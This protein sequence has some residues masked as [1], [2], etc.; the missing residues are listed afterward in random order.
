MKEK[1]LRNPP[2]DILRPT[3]CKLSLLMYLKLIMMMLRI[4]LLKSGVPEISI[5]SNHQGLIRA[6]LKLCLEL[7]NGRT[8]FYA[9]DKYSK[10]KTEALELRGDQYT[11]KY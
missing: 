5:K 11:S 7:V 1:L 6:A 10:T 2:R 8:V 3:F 9:K 4:N